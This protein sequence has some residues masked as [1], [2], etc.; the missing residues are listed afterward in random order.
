MSDDAVHRYRAISRW[1]GSTAE[2]YE[3]YERRHAVACPP[4]DAALAL[5]SDPSFRGDGSLLNPEQLVLAAASSCQLLSFLAVAARARVGVIS[6]LDEAE[7]EMPDQRGPMS[8]GRI[9]LRPH[10]V[11][12]PGTSE[13]RLRHLVEVAHRECYVANSLRSEIVVS[14]TIEI[15]SD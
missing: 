12:R 6:Y 8:I 14:P 11:V 5:S 1:H 13:A 3:S 15:S 4:A 10:I 2:G 7:A 9:V